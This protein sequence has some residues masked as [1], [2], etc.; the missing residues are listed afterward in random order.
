MSLLRRRG[1]PISGTT[2]ERTHRADVGRMTVSVGDPQAVEQVTRHLR[3]LPDVI[4]V[5]ATSESA[6]RREFALARVRCPQEQEAALQALLQTFGARS[7]SAGETTVIEAAGTPAQ[8]DEFFTHLEA[9]G[10][11]ESA[12]TATIA[13]G[14]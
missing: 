7:I 2:L 14:T 13:L 8:L 9:F 6:I 3:K 1:F 11:E 4:E 12:R 10:I 5:A